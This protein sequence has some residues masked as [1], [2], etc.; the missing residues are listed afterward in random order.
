MESFVDRERSGDL[1]TAEIIIG[2][3]I[4]QRT[5]QEIG[6]GF[7]DWNGVQNALIAA[8]IGECGPTLKGAKG[9]THGGAGILRSIHAMGRTPGIVCGEVTGKQCG[10]RLLVPARH[11]QIEGARI[12]MRA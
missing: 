8:H 9:R 4:Q 7:R 5:K 6:E 3:V 1:H 2:N 12:E 11:P 10:E